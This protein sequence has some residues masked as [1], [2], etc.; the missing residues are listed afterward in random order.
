LLVGHT[1]EDIDAIFALIWKK[2]FPKCIYDPYEFRDL[3]LDALRK[4]GDVYVKDIF[5]VPGG[6]AVCIFN[7]FINY[8]IVVMITDYKKY[9]SKHMDSNY[10]R[11][12]KKEWTSLQVTF[13]A[14]DPSPRYPLGVKMTYRAYS[15]VVS[16][17]IYITALI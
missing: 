17:R 9:L 5:A 6:S 12:F 15:Q 4:K 10:S 2:L 14:V 1:H 8:L 13:E 7:F 3:I 16:L 11:M